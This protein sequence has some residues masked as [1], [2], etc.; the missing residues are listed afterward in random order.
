MEALILA[1][2]EGK[3]MGISFPKSLLKIGDTSI[4]KRLI[5]Q[6]RE[7][8]IGKI[9]LVTGFEREAVVSELSG[10]HICEVINPSYITSDNMASF[11]Y[12][13]ES[14]ESVCIVSH[15]DIIAD[16]EIMRRLTETEGEIVLPFDRRSIT[17][18]SM[19]FRIEDGEI[20][21]IGKDIPVD[22]AAGE[23]LPMMKFSCEALNAL[24]EESGKLLAEGKIK[25]YIEVPLLTVI[26]S[27]KFKVDIIDVT[28]L[29]WI[30]VD[31]PTDYLS[32]QK[33]FDR[34]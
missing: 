6:F 25:S 12:G 19:K 33:M 1:A 18:E 15:A 34:L 24:R 4:L 9:T 14:I 29:R 22:Q 20:I 2:G 27:K 31:E 23:S 5:S 10:L 13:S 28:G 3:R 17:P 30:E 16:D 26:K 8:G 32:A 7:F 21:E 11:R